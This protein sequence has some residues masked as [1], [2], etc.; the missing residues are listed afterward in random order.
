MRLQIEVFRTRRCI[1]TVS[2]VF[3]ATTLCAQS[4]TRW[5]GF[6]RFTSVSEDERGKSVWKMEANIVNDTGTATHS[7]SFTS[8]IDGLKDAGTC[9]GSYKTTMSGGYGEGTNLYEFWI[10]IP[11]CRGTSERGVWKGEEESAIT[12]EALKGDDPNRMSGSIVEK[13]GSTTQ[14]WEWNFVR[15]RDAELIVSPVDYENWMPE[16]PTGSSKKG[17][18]LGIKL[19]VQ[20]RQGGITDTKVKY[21]K[22][23]LAGT[24]KQ[25]GTTLN[26]PFTS[27]NDDPDLRFMEGNDIEFLDAD[28][29]SIRVLSRDGYSANVGLVSFDGGGWSKLNVDAIMTDG[30]QLKGQLLKSGGE[31]DIL[32]PKRDGASKIA[33]S[34]LKK[35]PALKDESDDDALQGNPNKGDGLSTYEEYR[36]VIAGGRFKR[37]NP[38]LQEL[39]IISSQK[40]YP[41]F[42]GGLALFEQATGVQTIQF[43]EDELATDRSVNKNHGY[44]HTTDQHGM[45]IQTK[46]L[47]NDVIGE[48]QPAEKLDKTPGL[49]NLVAIDTAANTR[50]YNSNLTAAQAGKTRVPFSKSDLLNNT[51]AHELGHGIHLGHHG[52]PSQEHGPTLTAGDSSNYLLVDAY[53][54]EIHLPT[55]G[56]FSISGSVGVQGCEASGDLNCIMAY[57]SLYQ[58]A[59]YVKA[60]TRKRY[61]YLAVPL[62]PVGKGLC[63]SSKGTGI[64][65]N[66]DYFGDAKTGDC[67]SQIKVKDEAIK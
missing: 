9:F 13:N 38:T 34:W 25:P 56:N 37:L 48:N 59:H 57:T 45:R 60:N 19:K 1:F 61:V 16:P 20:T 28:G 30:T 53:K 22:L 10:P 66:K 42:Q 39:A 46:L 44:A 18:V 58:W 7:M 27:A 11:P 15:A 26:F 5:T 64:N 49:S 8:N 62:L 41:V 4:P 51:I 12:V 40:E 65:A 33:S 17:N 32:I 3:L 14:T 47:S 23:S 50:I 55:T 29:Q 63:S 67:Q 52:P 24:S 54:N 2:L 6:A 36:G 31:Y 35:Y 43:N 21:F